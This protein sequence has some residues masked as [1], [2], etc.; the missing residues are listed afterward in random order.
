[1]G[2]ARHMRYALNMARRR[3]EEEMEER[4]PGINPLISRGIRATVPRFNHWER[5][6]G[7]NNYGYAA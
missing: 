5:V 1:M 6:P 7:N 3:R 2:R 4:R